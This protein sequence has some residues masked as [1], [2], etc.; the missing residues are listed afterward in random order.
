[1]AMMFARRR[2]RTCSLV[3]GKAAERMQVVDSYL[4]DGKIGMGRRR[5][6]Q[7]QEQLA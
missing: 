3:A 2:E 6:L 7:L 5:G 4:H 1:M